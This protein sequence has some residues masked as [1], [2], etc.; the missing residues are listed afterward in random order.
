M[1]KGLG[2]A[3]KKDYIWDLFMNY[4]FSDS[5]QFKEPQLIEDDE[6]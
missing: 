6:E 4:P 5:K 1:R 3:N 2:N